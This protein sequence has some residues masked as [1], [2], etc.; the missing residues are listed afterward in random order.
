MF[1]SLR[2]QEGEPV[3]DERVGITDDFAL[4][5]HR[6]GIQE[7]YLDEIQAGLGGAR[8]HTQSARIC[9]ET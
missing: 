7:R 8:D 9:R 5:V 1:S 2:T 6:R 3:P 4:D